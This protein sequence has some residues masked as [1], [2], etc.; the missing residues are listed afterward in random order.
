M[1][2]SF[3]ELLC[4]NA[5]SLLV[6]TL[7]YQCHTM[8]ELRNIFQSE[9]LCLLKFEKIEILDAGSLETSILSNYVTTSN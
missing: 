4:I 1:L 3:P 2:A 5:K 8:L 9:T 6:P 7:Y